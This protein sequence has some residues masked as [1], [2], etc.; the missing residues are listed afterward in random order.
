MRCGGYGCHIDPAIALRRALAEAVQ[1]RV[2]M[3]SGARDDFTE[4]NFEP[5][6]PM[7]EPASPEPFPATFG[8]S[9]VDDRESVIRHCASLVAAVTGTEPLALRLDHD[10]IAIPAV[11][12]VAP[13]LRLM[14]HE[15]AGTIDP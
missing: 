10:D 12:V 13:G 2:A 5:S 6:Q 9:G 8:W 11:K 7:A 4:R 14:S 15:L 1:S 3:R